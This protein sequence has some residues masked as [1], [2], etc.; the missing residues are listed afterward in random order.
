MPESLRVLL[1][2][3]SEDDALLLVHALQE[4]GFEVHSRRVD[5]EAAYRAALAEDS[6]DIIL[7]D[8]ALPRFSGIAAVRIARDLGM[9]L[10]IILVSGKAGEDTAVEAMRAGAQDYLLKSNLARLT[11]AITRE[12][13]DA[14]VR[15]ERRAAEEALQENE[16]RLALAI[17]AADL[18][19]WDWNLTTDELRWSPRCLA[20]YGFAADT[21]MSYAR[22][23]DVLHPDDRARVDQAVRTA[24]ERHEDYNI[25][26]RAIWPDGSVHWI[27]SR[28]RAF[29][30]A[31][32]KPVRMSG[33]AMDITEQKTAEEERERLLAVIQRRW[34][35]LD[36]IFNAIVDPTIAYNSDGVV[37][38]VN[39]AMVMT[40]GR[41]PTGMSELAVARE[42][43]MCFPDG[44]EVHEMEVP[45]LRA[46]RGEPVKGERLMITDVDGHVMILLIS[47]SPL[48]EEGQPW[49]AVSIWHDIT[50][51]ERL[52]EEVQH[53]TAELDATLN[54]VADGLII[55]TPAGEIL[56]DNPAARC[57][58]DGL[59][60]DEEYSQTLPRTAK[61]ACAHAGWESVGTGGHAR[62]SRRARGDG[63]RRSTHLPAKRRQGNPRLGHGGAHPPA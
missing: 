28:G 50:K 49:G 25:E 29:Y 60:L 54:S 33:V 7:A 48:M 59:L 43:T 8:Y 14:E 24:L 12:L 37:I 58:L 62:P 22:F 32:G 46:L 18:G 57:L 51:R 36:A 30:A 41:D 55:Y 20:L 3:D 56:L 11:P 9:D 53:R 61:P 44:R 5:L 19:T 40:L 10:P 39:P 26:M 38:K 15:R 45:A 13:R 2:E 52:L 47:T 16:Q 63:N 35:E 6:W 21:R 17:R 27:T 4:G 31:D 42:L 23:L 34:S 1:V